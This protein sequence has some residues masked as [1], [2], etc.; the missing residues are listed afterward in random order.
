MVLYVISVDTL[1]F[2]ETY[3]LIWLK[4]TTCVNFDG[5]NNNN[6]NKTKFHD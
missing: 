2:T 6:N 3:V 1:F 5:S 4:N